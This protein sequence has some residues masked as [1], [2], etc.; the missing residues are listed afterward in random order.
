VRS[1]VITAGGIGL[2]TVGVVQGKARNGE[3]LDTADVE[4]VNG[5]V[6]DVEVGDFGVV[7]LLQDDEVVGPRML[8]K[9]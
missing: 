5:P 9:R 8:L 3:M 4:A 2:V 1:C 6:L 7:E